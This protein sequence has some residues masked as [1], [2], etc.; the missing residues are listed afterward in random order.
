[1]TVA[2]GFCVISKILHYQFVYVLSDCHLNRP[3]LQQPNSYNITSILIL[4]LNSFKTFVFIFSIKKLICRSGWLFL[5]SQQVD[6]HFGIVFMT[7]YTV[8]SYEL[9]LIRPGHIYGLC[10][11]ATEIFN[12]P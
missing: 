11:A 3:R 8:P 5:L 7:R 2:M 10:Y 4:D 6:S 12:T 1:M 9:C